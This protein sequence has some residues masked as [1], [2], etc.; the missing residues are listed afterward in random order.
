[1]PPESH[2]T[3]DAGFLDLGEMRDLARVRLNGRDRGILWTK[4]F[5]VVIGGSAKADSDDLEVEVTNFWPNR[6]IDGQQLPPEMRLTRTNITRVRADSPLMPSGLLGPRPWRP[7][8][9]RRL[10]R[11]FTAGSSTNTAAWHTIPS[12]NSTRSRLSVCR[13]SPPLR[14]GPGLRT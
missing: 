13:E 12:H 1:M 7:E 5:R 10:R 4:P 9:H 14:I 8:R 6:L 2:F 3:Q 11:P